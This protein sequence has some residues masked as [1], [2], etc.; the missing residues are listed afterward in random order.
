MDERRSSAGPRFAYRPEGRADVVRVDLFGE[1]SDW[2]NPIPL[3]REQDGTFAC[4][5]DLPPGVYQYKLRVTDATG[6][7][8]R[9]VALPARR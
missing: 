7:R 4:T 3:R 5:I 1:T 2:L 9:R 6:D 8:A